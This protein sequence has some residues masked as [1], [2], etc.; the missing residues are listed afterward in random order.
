M[1]TKGMN[2]KVMDLNLIL[3][4]LNGWE[5]DSRKV[6][7]GKVFRAWK[8]YPFEVLNELEKRDLIRQYPK[9]IVV[10]KEGQ[11]YAEGLMHLYLNPHPAARGAIT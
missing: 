10:T 3:I 7:G 8:N 9:S 6:P 4:F 11:T 1:T 5:E 2:L